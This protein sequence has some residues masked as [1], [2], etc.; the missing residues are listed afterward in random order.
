MT[1]AP[2]IEPGYKLSKAVPD[3]ADLATNQQT[4]SGTVRDNPASKMKILE[5]GFFIVLKRTD[6]CNSHS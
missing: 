2:V 6:E 3:K 1:G 5:V 4:W